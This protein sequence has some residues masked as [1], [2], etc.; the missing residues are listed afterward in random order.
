VAEAFVA[1]AWDYGEPARALPW[2]RHLL[3]QQYRPADAPLLGRPERLLGGFRDGPT[4]LDVQIDSVQ[5]IGSALLG[6]EALLSG[7]A[8]PGSLP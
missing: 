3:R 5:H 1:R 6:V 2:G 4:D 7:R 8:R